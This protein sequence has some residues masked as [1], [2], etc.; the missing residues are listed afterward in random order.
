MIAFA[1]CFPIL[2]N[3][4][5]GV[6][7][8]SPEVR[9]TASMLQVGASSECSASTFP[10][11]SRSIV[12]G[13]RV[14]VSLG[15]VAVVISEFVGEGEGLGRYIRLQQT[16]FDIPAMYCGLLFLGLLGVRPQPPLPRRRAP[17]PRLALRVN[18]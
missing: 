10:A 8:V 3:T 13:L 5:E 1:L 4:I 16:E 2:V 11:R 14:A 6:R 9:D 18:R 7:A 15:L 17:R 12:A